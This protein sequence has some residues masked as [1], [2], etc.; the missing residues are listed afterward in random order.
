M[1]VAL[2]RGEKLYVATPD[3]SPCAHA[4]S[5]IHPANESYAVINENS[6]VPLELIVAKPPLNPDYGLNLIP[7]KGSADMMTDWFFRG[8]QVIRTPLLTGLVS[9]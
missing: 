6:A 1:P 4:W 2:N 9:G 5:N 7:A 3:F 8:K